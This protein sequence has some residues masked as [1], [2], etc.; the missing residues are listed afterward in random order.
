[1]PNPDSRGDTRPL[2]VTELA[3]NLKAA[4]LRRLANP[5]MNP[6]VRARR[7]LILKH[8]HAL[9]CR[10]CKAHENELAVFAG[11]PNEP[12]RC[13]RRCLNCGDTDPI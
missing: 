12:V 7:K 1:M 10:R 3:D 2:S 6:R 8:L 5:W 9:P 13:Y 11:S 4:G